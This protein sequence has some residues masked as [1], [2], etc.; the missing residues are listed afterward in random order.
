[1]AAKFEV[2]KGKRGDFRFRLKAANGKVICDGQG[3][4]SKD[5]CMKGIES[6]KKNAKGAAVTVTDS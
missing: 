3:Y 6:I 4:K 2:Y 1:M 5:A